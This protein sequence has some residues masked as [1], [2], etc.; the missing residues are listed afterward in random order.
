MAADTTENE[1]G[2]Q[3]PVVSTVQRTESDST[4]NINKAAQISSAF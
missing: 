3:Y 2:V 4:A 1:Q